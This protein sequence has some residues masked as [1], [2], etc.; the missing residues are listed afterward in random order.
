MNISFFLHPK[1]EVAFLYDTDTIRQGLEK[2]KH[3]GYTAIPVLSED[4]KYIGTISEGDILWTIVDF[5]KTEFSQK[6]AKELEKML[7]A[8]VDFRWE[9]P[10]VTIDTS[11]DDLLQKAMGQNFVPVIDD[12]GIFIGIITRKDIIQYFA[13]KYTGSNKTEE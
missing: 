6:S 10:C 1:S 3:Y 5:N 2:L 9:Y 7:I 13:A 12:R 4:N 11:M 8:D